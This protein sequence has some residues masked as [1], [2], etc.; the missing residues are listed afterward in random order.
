MELD[1][2]TYVLVYSCTSVAP[3]IQK[4][5]EIDDK[6]MFQPLREL[7]VQ[8]CGRRRKQAH[9]E[10]SCRS[11]G[12]ISNLY[13]NSFCKGRR[14]PWSCVLLLSPISIGT[15]TW[16]TYVVLVRWKYSCTL[17]RSPLVEDTRGR[18]PNLKYRNNFLNHFP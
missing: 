14:E 8:F 9:H 13:D 18:C 10:Q 15:N 17:H 4:T 11:C 3:I 12:I 5:H 7:H 1:S 6:H 2:R 16:V